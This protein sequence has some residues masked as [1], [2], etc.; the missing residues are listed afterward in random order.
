MNKAERTKAIIL[1]MILIAI[2]GIVL[3][4]Q[5]KAPTYK[6]ATRR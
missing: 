6:Y 5:D 1:L 3:Y 2:G 4:G